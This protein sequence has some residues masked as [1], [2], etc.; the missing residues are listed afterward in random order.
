MEGFHKIIGMSVCRVLILQAMLRQ[1]GRDV[2]EHLL[3]K[4]VGAFSELRAMA[5]EGL[6]AYPYST[7]EV[8][9]IVKHLQ[10][11][12][13]EGVSS[14]ARNVFDFDTHNPDLLQVIMRVLHRHGI[15]AGASSSSVR[16]SPQYP[17]PAL[18]QIGQWIVKTDNAMTLDCHHL[19]VAL[20]FVVR[21]HQEALQ[22]NWIW[23]RS[24]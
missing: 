8:V 22:Q 19:P 6:I 10:E 17:L 1:Y 20:K 11:F 3:E 23:R 9:A 13:H 15:P 14:V 18:Q 16:L 7:R 5:D 2:P 24:M 12:P 21:D 4:L